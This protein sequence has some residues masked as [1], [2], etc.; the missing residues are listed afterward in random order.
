MKNINKQLIINVVASNEEMVKNLQQVFARKPSNDEYIYLT[1]FDHELRLNRINIEKS[2]ILIVDSEQISQKDL[3]DISLLNKERIPPTII[4]LATAWSEDQLI[5]LMRAGVNEVIH[6]PLNGTSEDL[7]DAIERIR[8][9]ANIASYYKQRGKIISCISCKGGAGATMVGVNMAYLLSEKYDKKVLFID[10]H[11][12]YGDAAYYLT[13]TIAASNVADIV[14]QPYLNSVT[15]AAAAIQVSDNYYLLPSSNSIEKSSGIQPHH[16]DTLLSVAAYEYDYIFLDVSYTLDSIA[17]RALDRSDLIYIITQPT[18]AYL[19]ALVNIYSVFSELS[20]P[21]QRMKLVMNKC[22][23]DAALPVEKINQ[24]FSRKVD[25]EIP[26]ESS[27]VDESLNAGIPI[28][29]MAK[30]NAV[31]HA[32]ENLV[33]TLEGNNIAEKSESIISKIFHLKAS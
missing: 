3:D 27:V 23:V 24:L 29:K 22:D 13:D 30:M 17:M 28:V 33:N 10:L 7:L 15:I 31:S 18:L 4:Y 1:R 21:S 11:P 2:N 25:S 32:I 16:I 19:K 9:K 5:E 20:Y 26:Y 6:L 14:A 12:Q 8:Q